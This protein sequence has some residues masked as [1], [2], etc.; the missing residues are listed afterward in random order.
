[1]CVYA[2]LPSATGAT[3]PHH[4]VTSDGVTLGY[5]HLGM[6]A[7]A[8]WLA[9]QAFP[10]LKEALLA[11]GPAYQLRVVGELHTHT[12]AADLWSVV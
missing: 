5:S 12:H 4:V 7:A 10:Q 2:R 8:R 9:R 6:L 1:M 11:A 3:K